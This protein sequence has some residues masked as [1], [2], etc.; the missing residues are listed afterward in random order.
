MTNML[1]SLN[2]SHACQSSFH[3]AGTN[4]KIHLRCGKKIE[5]FL[6]WRAGLN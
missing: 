4:K 3:K 6:N 1:I 5:Y 2:N